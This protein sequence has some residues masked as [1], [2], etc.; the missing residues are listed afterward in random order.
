MNFWQQLVTELVDLEQPGGATKLA[1]S[2]G[3]SRQA[4]HNWLSAGMKPYAVHRESLLRIT[5]ERRNKLRKDALL[6]LL[7]AALDDLA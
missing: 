4:V 1:A 7:D 6:R 5:H 3:V 2:T